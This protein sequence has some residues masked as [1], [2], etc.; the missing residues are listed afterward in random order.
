M[1]ILKLISAL[2]VLFFMVGCAVNTQLQAQSESEEVGR[3]A[4]PVISEF[5][6]GDVLGAPIALELI[7]KNQ[8]TGE[9]YRSLITPKHDENNTGDIARSLTRKGFDEVKRVEYMVNLTPGVYVIDEFNEHT[10]FIMQ[11]NVNPSV[12]IE[13]KAGETVLSPLYIQLHSSLYPA[14]FL[15]P[16]SKDG[17]WD[18]FF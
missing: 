10:H 11:K 12:V 18:D 1:N 17:F 16:I 4:F 6:S 14:S 15:T 3:I 9:I 7:L 13:V 8:N 2:C 5:P